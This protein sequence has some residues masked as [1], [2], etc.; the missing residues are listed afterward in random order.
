[1]SAPAS[2]PGG[3][4]GDWYRSDSAESPISLIR[5]ATRLIEEEGSFSA[6]VR[7]AGAGGIF[8]AL[9]AQIIQAIQ[10]AG[11]LTLAPLR[12]L[13]YG[14][15]LMIQAGFEGIAAVLGAG[16]AATVE[17]FSSGIG[18]LLGPLA[19][20]ASVGVVAITFIGLVIAFRRAGINPLVFVMGKLPFVG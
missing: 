3:G 9:V 6:F 16:S 4:G 7:D 1:M 13:G 18:S 15:V 20:P 8:F 2:G 11:S 19:Q 10:G 17:S 5:K 14:V 12:A